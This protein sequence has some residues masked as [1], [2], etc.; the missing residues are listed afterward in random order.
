METKRAVLLRE[1]ERLGEL[2]SVHRRGADVARL[3][4]AHHVVQRLQRLLD[5]SAVVPAMDLVEVHIVGA[6]PS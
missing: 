6:E 1:S 4:G 5:R 2:P 3:A